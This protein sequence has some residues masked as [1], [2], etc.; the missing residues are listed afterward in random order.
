MGF[1]QRTANPLT[2]KWWWVTPADGWRSHPQQHELQ[3]LCG[4]AGDASCGQC[5]QMRGCGQP[6]WSHPAQHAPH[7]RLSQ[8]AAAILRQQKAA[9]T[10]GG[11]GGHP[12][13]SH[14]PQHAPQHA[15]A[16]ASA[17]LLP[18]AQWGAAQ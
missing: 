4:H 18:H 15:L 8:A 17:A 3:A 13:W 5:S 2:A 10:G 6:W 9:H 16:H 12:W 1:H 11:C 7:M 14:P